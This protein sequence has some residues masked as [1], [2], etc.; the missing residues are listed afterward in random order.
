[1]SLLFLEAP[2]ELKIC[3][4]I[5]VVLAGVLRVEVLMLREELALASGSG[6]D[7]KDVKVWIHLFVTWM[8]VQIFF[9]LWRY[10]RGRDRRCASVLAGV[11]HSSDFHLPTFNS[12]HP[13]QIGKLSHYVFLPTRI[14]VKC[15]LTVGRAFHLGCFSRHSRVSA[16]PHR[17]WMS[18]HLLTS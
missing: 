17:D 10:Q 11:L 14:V 18:S 9:S 13:L 2:K 12:S 16:G 4:L 3:L 5:I 15:E 1:M 7:L 6:P 8:R